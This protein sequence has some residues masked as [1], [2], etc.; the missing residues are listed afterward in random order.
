MTELTV[1]LTPLANGR[2][3]SPNA[4]WNH[5]IQRESS[6]IPDI[7]Q[8][9][10]DVNSGGNEAQGLFQITPRTWN[11]HNGQQFAPIPRSATPAQQAI[12]AARIFTA[13]PSGGDWGAGR[14]GRENADELAA[15]LVPADTT[16]APVP[17]PVT[18]PRLTALAAVRPDFNEYP[19]F[20][21][22]NQDRGGTDVDLWLNHTEEGDMNADALVKWMDNNS[23][24]Y[25]YAGSQDP[26]DGGVT[27][28]DMVDTDLASWS[29]MNSNNRSINACYAGS[30]TSWS[31]QEWVDKAGKVIDVFAYLAVQD[32]IKY[33][34][35]A[36]K[37]IAAPYSDPPGIADHNYCS[38]Y[39]KDGNNHSDVG[40]N[41]P[42]DVYKAAV[43]KYWAAAN[44]T[45][46]PAPDPHPNPTPAPVPYDPTQNAQ[47]EVLIQTRGRFAMLGGQTMI[48]TLAQLR[49]HL[50]GSKDAGKQGFEW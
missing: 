2:W 35:L 41:F 18:D 36:A 48:E 28:V 44:A 31:R 19:N 7:I 39:L 15:G 9:I 1:P 22:N 17:T 50:T 47:L 26:N 16:G 23:V 5:L 3:G 49:D 30:Y 4:A 46:P 27:V 42:W 24:S 13:N 20:S 40:P 32:T 45:T 43:A 10:V 37:V 6:G 11:A 34:K 29:V 12:V 33:P 21:D 14:P 8:Q 38:V 25:H